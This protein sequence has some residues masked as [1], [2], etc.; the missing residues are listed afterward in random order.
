MNPLL[1]PQLRFVL[2][3]FPVF[4]PFCHGANNYKHTSVFS[5][6]LL[7]L[8]LY[9]MR[10]QFQEPFPHQ[11][12][13]LWQGFYPFYLPIVG[14]QIVHETCLLQHKCMWKDEAVG[15]NSDLIITCEAY[16]QISIKT[17]GKRL[18]KLGFCTSALSRHK[19]ATQIQKASSCCSFGLWVTSLTAQ[20]RD[21]S[22]QVYLLPTSHS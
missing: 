2:E 7:L 11:F 17:V 13:F 4:S 18:F 12:C 6:I 20:T 8:Q 15:M 14:I 19:A 5:V 22:A 21:L 3:H 10:S 16:L 1:C 9:I